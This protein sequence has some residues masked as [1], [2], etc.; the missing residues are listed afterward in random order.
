MLILHHDKNDTLYFNPL[1][2]PF[3]KSAQRKVR[4]LLKRYCSNLKI[5]LA[6][7][8]FKIKNLI[9][10]KESVPRSLHSCVVYRFTCSGCNSVYV[11]QTCR[12]ISTRI[13]EHLGTD[14]NSHIFKHLQSSIPCKDAGYDSCFKI[15]D[16]AKSYHHLKIKESMHI[17]REKPNINKQVQHYNISLTF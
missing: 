2:L 10:V 13:R 15:I 4:K 12:H 5:K 14:K 7:S 8:S 17:L 11:G 3:S 9:R 1:N 6:F 16:T